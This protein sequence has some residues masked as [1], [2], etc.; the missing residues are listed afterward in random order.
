MHRDFDALRRERVADREPVTF[1]VGGEQFTT[2]AVLPAG[3]VLDLLG[4]RGGVAYA[5]RQFLRGA[6]RD[7]DQ[8]VD[9]T[10]EETTASS[11]V[12]FEALCYRRD[13]PI[14][15]QTIID[16]VDWLAEVYAG[17]P[18]QRS[19]GSPTGP[20]AGSASS[21]GSSVAAATTTPEG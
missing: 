5:Y 15:D 4:S 13:D 21:N 3:V 14:D 20:R 8:T 19:S 2:L 16:I 6:L 18:T 17:H 12:R 11:L 9:D 10:G 1:S 7:D